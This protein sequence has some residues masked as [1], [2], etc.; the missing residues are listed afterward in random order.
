[1]DPTGGEKTSTK[2]HERKRVLMLASGVNRPKHI[3]FNDCKREPSWSLKFW[4]FK[5]RRRGLVYVVRAL[6]L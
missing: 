3:S 6:D 5:E 4:K 1:M 2:T